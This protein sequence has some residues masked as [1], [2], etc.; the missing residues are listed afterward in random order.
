MIYLN[1]LESQN[2]FDTETL[3]IIALLIVWKLEL[4]IS[5]QTTMFRA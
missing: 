2:I 1:A 5:R 3:N 4:L